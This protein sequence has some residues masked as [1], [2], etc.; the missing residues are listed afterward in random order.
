MAMQTSKLIILTALL[1]FVAAS[2]PFPAL[3]SR[4]NQKALKQGAPPASTP[5][6]RHLHFPRGQSIG[7]VINGTV[8]DFTQ[9]HSEGK[10][11]GPARGDYKISSKSPVIFKINYNGAE[12]PELLEQV[13][14]NIDCLNLGKFDIVD[15]TFPHLTH[16]T[17]LKRIDLYNTDTTD[18]GI[19]Y[20]AKL[21]NLETLNASSTSITG[22]TIFQLPLPKLTFLAVD[23]N[24]LDRGSIAK[25]TSYPHLKRLEIQRTKIGD[26]ELV[27][28]GKLKELKELN[29][30]GN[31]AISDIGIKHLQNLKKLEK[32]D[33]RDCAVTSKGLLASNCNWPLR[34]LSLP[35]DIYSVA[36]MAALHKH[37]P[38]CFM[39]TRAAPTK[40]QKEIFAP[41]H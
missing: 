9:N 13:S 29:L 19:A 38:N 37:F 39:F 1:L 11:I 18:V 40:Y 28:I 2:V 17:N 10:Y 24:I 16:L 35:G 21:I 32:L 31:P 30:A 15:S 34:T 3:A 7:E 33:L 5:A 12:K 20:L 41:L 26:Q 4:A 25:I 27:F 8:W 23:C 14:N 6:L 36:E 22:K